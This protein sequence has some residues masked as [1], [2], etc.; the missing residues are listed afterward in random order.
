MKKSDEEIDREARSLIAQ[1]GRQAAVVAAAELN[2]CID[3][4]DWA[5]RD[6]WARIIRRIHE[7]L[8]R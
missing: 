2:R 7:L 4:L 3:R 1:H 5:A 8:P 6:L